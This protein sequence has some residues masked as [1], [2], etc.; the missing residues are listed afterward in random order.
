MTPSETRLK[1]N[2]PF[3]SL[4]ISQIISYGLLFYVFAQLK[5]PLAESLNI[6]ESQ[7]LM[8]VSGSLILSAMLAPKIG[9]WFDCYGALFIMARGFLIGAIG[10]ALLPF[11]KTILGLWLC[12]IL[13][14]LAYG[15]ATY[16]AAFAA[17]I[18]INEKHSRKNI[19]YIAF[20]GGV[21]STI[22]WLTIGPLY[23]KSNLI[24][25]CFVIAFVLLA[26]SFQIF[27]LDRKNT[28]LKGQNKSE[29]PPSFSWKILERNE[30]IAIIV[31]AISSSTEYL[32]FSCATLLWI[33]WFYLQFNDWA[34][35]VLLASFYGPFQV[36]GRVLEMAFGHK[37]DARKT[38]LVAFI[39]AP[40]SLLLV[41]IPSLP[42]AFLSMAVFGIGHGILTVTFG[43]VTNM[44]FR[45]EVY[46]R[47]KGWIVLPRG[48]GSALGPT[49]GGVLFMLS[50]DV[51]F[52]FLVVTSL[53]SALFFAVL[54]MLKPGNNNVIMKD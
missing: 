42:L 15:M 5:T 34:L 9:S 31:L 26:M 49:L 22:T 19:S 1:N 12:M 41:Q 13:I 21:A 18:Q 14:G 16:D 50:H 17:A 46:G 7:V 3:H 33:N 40:V 43:F 48:M 24:V 35:A 4:G 32:I 28:S 53:I 54:L 45:A 25:T 51:F 6:E 47:A 44:F 29:K 39:C 23:L 20:Y 11:V 38:G 27:R 8:A 10:M 52:G 36:V 37:F 2:V 30:K